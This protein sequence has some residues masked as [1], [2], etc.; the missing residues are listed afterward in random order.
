MLDSV[1]LTISVLALVIS[2]VTTWL[3]LFRRGCVRMTRPSL[4]VFLRDPPRPG[5]AEGLPKIFLRTL[6]FSTA[7]RGRV[8]ESM[9]VTLVRSETRQTFSFWAHGPRESLSPGSG[10]F[11]GET[12]VTE[13]HHFV[14]PDDG[15]G[16]RF[17]AGRYTLCVYARLLGE[18][19]PRQLFGHE[20]EVSTEN[21]AKLADPSTALYFNWGPDSGRYNPTVERR[22]PAPDPEQF[23]AA[24]GLGAARS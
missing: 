11:I 14:V 7:I 24:V 9:Y 22:S 2:C 17:I 8:I 1:T 18:T 20:L 13:N 23:F 5:E 3:T 12:G 10:M 19:Q 21:A 16:F 15:N 6:L 4:I